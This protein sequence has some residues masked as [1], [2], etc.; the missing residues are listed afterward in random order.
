MGSEMCI[1]DRY[2]RDV[3][4]YELKKIYGEFHTGYP[5]DPGTRAWIRERAKENNIPPIVRR[6]WATIKELAPEWYIVK[7]RT[8]RKTLLDFLKQ[9]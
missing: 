5:S 8:R 6:S 1:R 9:P 2:Y 3:N 4:L 7:K